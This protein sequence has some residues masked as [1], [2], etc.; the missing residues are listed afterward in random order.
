MNKFQKKTEV[1]IREARLL[2]GLSSTP[3]QKRKTKRQGRKAKRKPRA[4]V[5]KKPEPEELL[6]SPLAPPKILVLP[7]PIPQVLDAPLENPWM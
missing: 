3:R 5:T 1:L 4:R 6:E 7:R 2:A